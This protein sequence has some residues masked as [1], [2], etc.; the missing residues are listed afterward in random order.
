MEKWKKKALELIT[1]LAFTSKKYPAV[2]PYKPSKTVISANE[3]KYFHRSAPEK[4]G[5][6]SDRICRMIDELENEKRV[7]LHNLLVVKDGVVIAECSHPGYDVN[8]SHLSHSMSKTLT[9]MAIGFLIDEG[10]LTVNEKLV[11]IF[12]EYTPKDKKF[13]NITVHHLLNMSSGVAFSELGAVTETQWLKAFFGARVDFQPGKFFAY[14]SM[15]SYVLS[16][17]VTKLSGETLTD[18]LTERLFAPLGI[19]NGFL[20]TSPEGIEKGGWGVYLSCESWAK[21]G[22]MMLGKGKFEGEQVLPEKWAEEMI[23]THSISP[24][25]SGEFN[26]GYH[27]WVGRND[28]E[29]LFNGM[30]GQNV[31]V[32]TKNNVVVS[33]NAE[34]SEL[35]QKS[36]A[37]EIIQ[38]YFST[39]IDTDEKDE[40]ASFAA[41]R[42]KEK[43]FYRSRHW[44][45]SREPLKGISY[46]LGLKTRK[47]FDRQWD[48]LL[49]TYTFANNNQGILPLFVRALQN[50][51]TGGIESFSFERIGEM[52]YFTSREGG[53]D[54]KFEVG[55]YDFKST[56]LDF[57]GEKYI[58][59]AIAEAIEDEDRNPVFKLE[60][61]F[62]ELPNTRRIK[63]TFGEGG[64]IIVRMDET[65][66]HNLAAPL[67]EALYVTNPKLA[68]GVS[69]IEK[70]VG[71][72]II[73]R[74]LESVVTP[75]LIG[76]NKSSRTY[77]NII[78]EENE[79][80]AESIKTVKPVSSLILKLAKETDKEE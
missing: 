9:G 36:A 66:N 79:K 32:S 25:K 49:G 52:L 77:Y 34:N 65:P 6:S 69:I 40:G 54:Y 30:L 48:S 22:V 57:N 71:D 11:N 13:S 24:K 1:G 55:L 68:F 60:F 56:V 23:K 44:I 8:I 80:V 20:E 35:F 17:I 39:D 78:E 10:R 75:T 2:I 19:K 16:A 50:N 3:H 45:K 31:W 26:Y 72:R 47:P 67:V 51:Y 21:I 29:F 37:L 61:I 41:L 74:K 58:I 18:F 14:N 12:P 46:R 70:R 5:I 42:K 62:P 38:K 33:M 53:T 28:G 64:K 63:I 4:H 27:L 43:E 15:N 59:N 73:V 7:N 76:V